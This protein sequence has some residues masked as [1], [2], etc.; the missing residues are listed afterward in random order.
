MAWSNIHRTVGGNGQVTVETGYWEETIN[1][2]DWSTGGGNPN[3]GLAAYTSS[4]PISTKDDFTVLMT[5][6]DDLTGNTNI[7]VEHSVDGT[8]W[9]RAAQSGTTDMSTADFTGGTDVSIIAVIQD[10][11]QVESTTGYFFV[12][13]AETH[14]SSKF[15]RFGLLDNGSTDDSAETVKFQIIPH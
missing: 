5:F 1:L 9:V 14:G 13:D 10:S 4:I 8:N 7:I 11:D 2:L 12:Y 3:Q 15:T 6:S